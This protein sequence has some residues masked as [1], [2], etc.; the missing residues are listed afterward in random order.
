MAKL[1]IPLSDRN[2]LKLIDRI[3]N[4]RKQY[5]KIKVGDIKRPLVLGGEQDGN[6]ECSVTIFINNQETSSEF[7]QS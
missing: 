5:G 1:I 6:Y 4:L 7:G 3:E 2:E